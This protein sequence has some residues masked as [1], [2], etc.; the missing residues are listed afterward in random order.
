MPQRLSEGKAFVHF[1]KKLQPDVQTELVL[2]A[3]M[4]EKLSSIEDVCKL[5]K[6][7]EKRLGREISS[8]NLVNNFNWRKRQVRLD[9]AGQAKV[10]EKG[11]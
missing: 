6:T 1:R 10:S 3:E 4:G 7:F 9:K 2:H 5:V 8:K 11:L